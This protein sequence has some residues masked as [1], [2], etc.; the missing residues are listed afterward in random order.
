LAE[1][2]EEVIEP[3]KSAGHTEHIPNNEDI[4][5]TSHFLSNEE[6]RMYSNSTGSFEHCI[7]LCRLAD[8]YKGYEA[9]RTLA[10]P[11]ISWT[12]GIVHVLISVLLFVNPSV[13]SVV[14]REITGGD[15]LQ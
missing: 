13:S 11:S 15:V 1:I 6:F 12:G 4:K 14:S 5:T 8:S 10:R 9:G 3:L 2:G 7:D